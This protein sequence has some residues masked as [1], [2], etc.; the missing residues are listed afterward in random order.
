MSEWRPVSD[1]PTYSVS[2]DGRVRNSI[3]G[4]QLKPQ[5]VNGYQHVTLCDE[6]GHHQKTI[7]R[8]VATEFLENPNQLPVVNHID[9]NKENNCAYNL[10]YCTQSDN[11]KHAYRTGLQEVKPEQI[12]YSLARARE[13]RM[14]PV[15]NIE[16]GR[17]Y[18]SIVECA[19]S[20]GIGPS[21]VG[22][23]LSG[24]VKRRRFEYVEEGGLK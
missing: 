16:T 19:N 3:T 24:K 9:G 6:K 12:K 1:C 22:F 23:H 10:E 13:V 20:E 2:D 21:G 11:M 4:R 7:H 15:R 5:K 17:C 14:R 8:L 18:K